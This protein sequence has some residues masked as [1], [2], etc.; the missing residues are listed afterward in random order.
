LGKQGTNTPKLI[1]IYPAASHFHLLPRQKNCIFFH[2]RGP[3]F[4]LYE[5]CQKCEY[6]LSLRKCPSLGNKVAIPPNSSAS[7]QPRLIITRSHGKQ[8]AFY[9][10]FRGPQ[11]H[12]Y[13]VCQKC[14]NGLPLRKCPSWGSKVPIPPNSSVSIQPPVIFTCYLGKKMAF[15]PISDGHNSTDMKCARN[16]RKVYH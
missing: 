10:H 15:F 7:I 9:F 1:C 2:F 3:Q 5:V 8:M 14:K 12:R 16:V 4:H 13:E 6:S 11:F